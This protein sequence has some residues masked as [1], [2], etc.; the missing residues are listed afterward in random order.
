MRALIVLIVLAAAGYGF[1]HFKN[2]SAPSAKDVEPLLEQYLLASG[3]SGCSG[4][5]SVTQLEH[6][7]VGEYADQFGGW[8]VY[9]NHTEVCREGG[10]SSTYDGS[11]DAARKVAA[12]FVRRAGGKLDVFTPGAFADAQKAMQQAMQ[13]A[14]DHAQVQSH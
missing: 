5:V 4:S 6:V 10:S 13:S 8:P 1:W 14:L 9:A 7:S 2:S 12:A 11:K 3:V